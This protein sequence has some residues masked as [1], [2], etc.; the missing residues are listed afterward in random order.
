[1]IETTQPGKFYAEYSL[2]I[3]RQHDQPK[4]PAP[5]QN[6]ALEKLGR[7]YENRN[8]N[9]GGGILVLPTGGGKTFT[10]V[11][12][13]CRGP[14]SRGCKVLWL[15]H[16]HHLLEQ[17]FASFAGG[18]G[19]I[20][21]PKPELRVRVVSGMKGEHFPVHSIR[22]TDDVVMC[23]LPMACR[24]VKERHDA[25]EGFLSSSNGK[26]IVVFD[27]AH[28]APAPSHRQLLRELRERYPGVMLLG[29]TATPTYG[30]ERKQGWLVELFPQGIVHQVTASE[31]MAVGILALPVLHEER[32]AF[33]PDFD[34]REYKKWL[35]TH[36]DLPEDIVNALATN[37]QRNNYIVAAY[38]QRRE[39]W[40]KTIVFADRWYQCDYLR[41]AFIKQ[42]VR[43]DVVYSHIDAD[44]GSAAA[45]NRR[46]ADENSRVLRAFKANEL[47]V[48][49]N[50]KMLTEGTDIPDVQ[51]VFL[52]RQSTSRI[53]LTQ[54]VG[55]AL[56]GPK[57]GGTAEAH[58]VSFIDDWKQRIN[59]ASY[60]QLSASEVEDEIRELRKRPPVHLIS[61]ELVRRLARQMDSGNNVNPSPYRQFLPIGWYLVEY[62]TRVEG[63]DDEITVREQVMVFDHNKGK[64]ASFLDALG[65]A[66]LAGWTEYDLP[67]D[68]IRSQL[69]SW[70]EVY[71]AGGA[72]HIGSELQRDLFAL[73][74]HM[75][76]N[77][78]QL[79]LFVPFD[80]H[81]QHDLDALAHKHLE[82]KFGVLQIS[83][84]LRKEY[85]RKDRFWS[86][87]YPTYS[88][89]K[90]HYDGCMNR[91]INILT[92][93]GPEPPSGGVSNPET[94]PD[95]EPTE[96]VKKM[97]K[98]RDGKRCLCCTCTSPLQVDHV[99]PRYLGGT[100]EPDNLQTLCKY[101]NR[102]K[103]ICRID[104]RK[105]K[106]LLKAPAAALTI[107]WMPSG[108]TIRD[109]FQWEMFIRCTFNFFYRCA[110]V[111]EVEIGQ[112]GER[113]HTWQVTLHPGNK[114]EWIQ[115]HLPGL[116]DRIRKAREAARLASAPSGIIVE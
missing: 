48:L 114:P 23:S 56:R 1:M 39:K 16:T 81:K 34:D 70:R 37:Q 71:F 32:T 28:H 102:D 55:R 20:D 99:V 76:Q 63:S 94:V 68:V 103:G 89:F 62:I 86:V 101:C 42:G 84:E 11:H 104:F 115:P 3:L 26:L 49:I 2:P 14:L 90:S 80:L 64:Y 75:A 51:T 96:D 43:A 24:A 110:A 31:L 83:N 46:G 25:M 108:D 72:D 50:V 88:A 6:T 35:G 109:V 15:A 30:N 111:A 40:G 66:D 116:I 59:W 79:P 74:R 5:H 95:A 78:R 58:I 87:F 18:A 13:A 105:V 9:G 61:I 21:E 54:M 47:D 93:D 85:I 12:F 33:T 100:N 106:T 27:E 69:E 98:A 112:R 91:L 107:G 19:L 17:A 92:G 113:F 52:T 29:L 36:R 38:L 82:D 65:V 73:A 41:E 53:L 7:W 45:R 22:P 4:Q 57:F 97:V 77:E 67:S 8:G 60:D 10:A 44:P